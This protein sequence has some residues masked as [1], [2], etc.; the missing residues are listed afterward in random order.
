MVEFSRFDQRHYPTLPV[1]EGYTAWA[2]TYE[3]T[4]SDLMDRRLLDRLTTVPWAEIA[5]AADL[6]CGAGRGGAWLKAKGVARLD[7]VDLTPGMLEKARARAV[8]DRL[9]EADVAATGLPDGA[10][11]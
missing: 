8:Y 2:P 4:V 11:D 3:Q 6:A 7:G 5:S 9:L 1:R 10:Y